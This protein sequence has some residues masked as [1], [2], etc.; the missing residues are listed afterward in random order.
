MLILV[1]V[2]LSTSISNVNAQIAAT[3]RSNSATNTIKVGQPLQFIASASGGSGYYT[4]NW[5]VN[6]MLQLAAQTTTNF[7]FTSE[8]SGSFAVSVDAYD[9]LNAHLPA[10]TSNTITVTVTGSSTQ[11]PA[12]HSASAALS[13]AD[14]AL[15]ALVILI[16]ICIVVGLIIM[17]KRKSSKNDNLQTAPQKMLK[18]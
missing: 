3:I 14:I 4:Y 17:R 12:G 6:G 18:K 15:V 8:I 11:S 1:F 16:A 9:A 10:G 2:A 13:T 5:Y 7:T